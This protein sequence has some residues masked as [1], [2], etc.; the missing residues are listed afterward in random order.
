MLALSLVSSMFI[1]D[2]ALLSRSK[3]MG[4]KRAVSDRAQGDYFFWRRDLDSHVTLNLNDLEVLEYNH[5]HTPGFS[6]SR[7]A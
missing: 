1:S 4:E 2:A 5:T 7:T 3:G 6:V